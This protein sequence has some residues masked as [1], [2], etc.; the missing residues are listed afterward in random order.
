MC[1]QLGRAHTFHCDCRFRFCSLCDHR[2]GHIQLLLS[3]LESVAILS[4]FCGFAV[5][6]VVS[7]TCEQKKERKGKKYIAMLS[8]CTLISLQASV[9]KERS[10]V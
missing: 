5:G 7:S 8:V 4:S 6:N 9:G 3:A 10:R 2:Q 1:I